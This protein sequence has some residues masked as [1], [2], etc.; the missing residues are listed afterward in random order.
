MGIQI[1]SD[2]EMTKMVGEGT[3]PTLSGEITISGSVHGSVELSSPIFRTIGAIQLRLNEHNRWHNGTDSGLTEMGNT[4]M[5][6]IAESKGYTSTF[7][8]LR[9]AFINMINL[10]NNHLAN[11]NLHF[12]STSAPF[13]WPIDTTM[14]QLAE[15]TLNEITQ[16]FTA[17]FAHYDN[18]AGNLSIHKSGSYRNDR[19]NNYCQVFCLDE[20]NTIKM[21]TL[22]K[23]FSNH[24]RI[25]LK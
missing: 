21:R 2:A 8:E 5:A 9:E 7:V 13:V 24:R 1:Y 3:I 20:Y 16:A 6:L 17:F 19:F 10:Y 14:H 4:M 12:G 18:H 25:Q 22:Q 15:A 23:H 11:S